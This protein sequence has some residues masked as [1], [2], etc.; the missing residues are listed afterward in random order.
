MRFERNPILFYCLRVL[1][2][3]CLITAWLFCGQTR[4]FGYVETKEYHETHVQGFKILI[5]PN[6]YGDKELT[7]RVLAQ[8]DHKLA[9]AKRR[10]GEN[11]LSKLDLTF[12]V[13]LNQSE[14]SMIYHPSRNWLVTNNENPEKV[15]AIEIPNAV[16][17]L[18]WSKTD[19]PMMVVHEI[20]HAYYFTVLGDNYPPLEK[21]WRDLQLRGQY[22]LVSYVHGGERMAYAGK[23]K[24]EYFAE[25]TEAFFGRN[26]FFPFTATDL[27]KYDRAGYEL[28]EKVW[29]T[30]L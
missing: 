15:N 27:F 30:E 13:D 14:T 21:L 6:L 7:K 11:H 18:E 20:A 10:I 25:I 2:L 3:A 4:V 5:S 29:G 26:D 22:Q 16:N 23:N 19:Q 8:L 9:D 28:M 1:R 12:W 24:I 17:F